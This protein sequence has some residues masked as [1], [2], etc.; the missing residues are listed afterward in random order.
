[1]SDT[2]R[3]ELAKQYFVNEVWVWGRTFTIWAFCNDTI[4]NVKTKIQDEEGFPP[5][6]QLLTYNGKQLD[7]DGY[8][9]TDYNLLASTG[10]QTCLE[11]RLRSGTQ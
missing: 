9:M 10:L 6:Q 2:I 11:L 7:V 5:E 3:I 1:M 8:T 4:A